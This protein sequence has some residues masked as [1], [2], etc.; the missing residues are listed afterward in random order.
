MVSIS[1]IIT[2]Y[3]EGKLIYNALD[4]LMQQS[5]KDFE[6]IIIND[7]ST[8]D[9]TNKICE[10]LSKNNL[11]QVIRNEK[12]VGLSGSRN[13]AVEKMK[14]DVSVFLDADDVLPENA[15]SDIRMTFEKDKNTDFVFG[16]YIKKETSCTDII[17]CSLIANEKGYLSPNLLAENWILLGTSPFKKSM[18]KKI[19]GYSLEFSNTC[20]DVDFWQRA[21]LSGANGRYINR[22]I[23]TWN[24]F[25][26]NMNSSTNHK[27]AVDICNYKN[28]EFYFRFSSN[29][30]KAFD[31]LNWNKDYIQ[32]KER[33]SLLKGISF[34]KI[35]SI[36]PLFLVP[37][38]FKI[39]NLLF[40][41]H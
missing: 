12:N 29:L 15:I 19:N 16:N 18:W 33:A 30:N 27:N 1:A 13:I 17:D 35:A 5:D 28:V 26:S 34:F 31:I 36:V 23:Y 25:S 24:F 2:C 14:G 38:Y 9:E 20:Q 8:D 3:K 4:S 39:Y 37:S 10:D 21:L 41:K 40:R 32:I 7:C 11:I 22:A 6:I